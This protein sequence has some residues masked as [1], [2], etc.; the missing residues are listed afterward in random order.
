MAWPFIGGI[1]RDM[2]GLDIY[3]CVIIYTCHFTCLHLIIPACTHLVSNHGLLLM[4]HV[5]IDHHIFL[6]KLKV[7]ALPCYIR[8]RYLI[9]RET[10]PNHTILN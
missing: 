5:H 2:H 9:L 7:G 1:E 3:V 6:L 10:K 4:D 8:R